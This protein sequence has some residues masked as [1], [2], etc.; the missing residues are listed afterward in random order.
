MGLRHSTEWRGLREGSRG[1]VGAV[2]I[3][4]V[5]AP[6]TRI[7]FAAPGSEVTLGR[8]LGSWLLRCTGARLL[9]IHGARVP[10]HAGGTTLVNIR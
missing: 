4:A 2:R 10:L 6:E 1:Q 9:S 3:F 5:F 7:V 8:D